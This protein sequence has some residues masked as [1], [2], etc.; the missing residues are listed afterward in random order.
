MY[1]GKKNGM[2]ANRISY[3]QPGLPGHKTQVPNFQRPFPAGQR[4]QIGQRNSGDRFYRNLE[5]NPKIR[6]GT[7]NPVLDVRMH[8]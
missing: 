8:F 4:C 1:T 3:T 6:A 5:E 2:L 7:L